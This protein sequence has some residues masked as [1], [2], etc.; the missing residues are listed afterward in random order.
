MTW[1]P[2]MQTKAEILVGSLFAGAAILIVWWANEPKSIEELDREAARKDK[3][4]RGRR[5]PEWMRR[6]ERRWLAAG[7]LGN[8]ML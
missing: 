8:R 7:R 6:L 4:Y 3:N 2:A 5:K 1:S